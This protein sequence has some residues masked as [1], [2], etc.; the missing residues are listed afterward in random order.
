M[1]KEDPVFAAE[2]EG[3]PIPQ[4]RPKVSR[5]GVYYGKK[6]TAYRKELVTLLGGLRGDKPPIDYPVHVTL[7]LAGLSPR[8]DLDNSAKNIMDA[9]VDAQVI[10]DDNAT[11]V[12]QLNISAQLDAPPRLI[13]EIRAL[14]P[15]E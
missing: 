9:L 15:G 1:A 10:Q 4:G 13:L 3:Q 11:V 7:I 6:S 2:I 12:R 5:F 14:A 8:A